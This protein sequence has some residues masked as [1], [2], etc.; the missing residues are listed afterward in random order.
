MER[1]V[2]MLMDAPALPAG[3][4]LVRVPLLTTA[5]ANSLPR[6]PAPHTVTIS[7]GDPAMR[8]R[9]DTANLATLGYRLVGTHVPRD[10]AR[11]HEALLLVRAPLLDGQPAWT[12]LVLQRA[13]R[14]FDCDLGP[15]QHA[16]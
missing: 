2:T 15:V 4:L 5:D 7:L 1:T 9:V 14:V 6:V 10:P 11:T 8:T 16:F 12:R 13:D 3:A